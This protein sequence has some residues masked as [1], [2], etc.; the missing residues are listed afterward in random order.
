VHGNRSDL[1]PMAANFLPTKYK[2]TVTVKISCPCASNRAPRHEGVLGE[3]RYF[4]AH[5]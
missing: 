5:S 3:W 4:S 1:Y 2:I